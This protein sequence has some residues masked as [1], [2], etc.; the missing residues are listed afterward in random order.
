MRVST[1]FACGVTALAL[2]G[3][4]GG[5]AGTAYAPP[6]PAYGAPP[7]V[8][9]APVMPAPVMPAPAPISASNT[10][11]KSSTWTNPSGTRTVTRSSTR[12]AGV[13]FDPNAMFAALAGQSAGNT[14]TPSAYAGTWQITD[15]ATGRTCSVDLKSTQIG[16]SYGAW[17]RL[18]SSQ[19]LF[20]VQKWQ[21]RGY[22]LVLLDAVG[23]PKAT[24]RATAPNRLD[25]TTAAG[26]ARISMWR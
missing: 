23:Q 14:A 8:T 12:S 15:G 11:T 19:E 18:C 17:T 26:G 24:L 20:G 10:K 2:A 4:Q 3:C 7:A 1:I 16:G 13:S 21:M 25:G 9:P 6:P 22:D 5:P